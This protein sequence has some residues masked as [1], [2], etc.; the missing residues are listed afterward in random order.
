M[1]EIGKFDLFGLEI[2]VEY[3][4]VSCFKDEAPEFE[5]LDAMCNGTCMIDF[6]NKMIES[7]NQNSRITAE[8]FIEF[9]I[10]NQLE[11]KIMKDFEND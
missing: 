11:E 4:V 1:S 10:Y 2:E 6:V 3:K 7:I 8:K 9:E 5:I